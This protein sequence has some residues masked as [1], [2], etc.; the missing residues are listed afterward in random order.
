MPKYRAL[1]VDQGIQRILNRSYDWCKG[2]N[3][4]SFSDAECPLRKKFKGN[5][6]ITYKDWVTMLSGYPN[7]FFT[8][9][10]A[11]SST[12]RGRCIA[13]N[14]S[15]DYVS[16]GISRVDSWG[17]TLGKRGNG[18]I[19]NRKPLDEA[20]FTYLDYPTEIRNYDRNTTKFSNILNE[21]PGCVFYLNIYTTSTWQCR[22][23]PSSK[24]FWSLN[25]WA[26]WKVYLEPGVYAAMLGSTNED[27]IVKFRF[28][29]SLNGV[30]VETNKFLVWDSGRRNSNWSR[31]VNGIFFVDSPAYVRLDFDRKDYECMIA[32]MFRLTPSGYWT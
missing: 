2:V 11:D 15:D 21:N 20:F 27:M 28:M 10:S 8:P 14:M 19:A 30:T 13:I 22:E 5:Q 18:P 24:S 16:A 6:M 32:T 3:A 7:K 9:G 23:Y 25:D 17:F 26:N 12:S 4:N 29:Y 31:A 1:T